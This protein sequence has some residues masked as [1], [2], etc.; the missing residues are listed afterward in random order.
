MTSTST[1]PLGASVGPLRGPARLALRRLAARVVDLFTVFF[2][3]FALAVTALFAVMPA[4]TD[5]LDIGPWGRTLAP[6]LLFVMIAVVYETV[7][8]SLRGQ[9][10]GKDLLCL[11]VTDGAGVPPAAGVSLGR[12]AL[13]AMPFL[14]PHPLLVA[15]TLV[16]LAAPM[17]VGRVSLHDLLTGT[18][19]DAYDA[20]AL[21]GPVPGSSSAEVEARYGPRSWWG[22]LTRDLRS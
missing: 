3:T 2:L 10:P 4:L 9:T 20:D 16:V 11:R 7:F 18:D 13:M 21:E 5:A 17:A 6:T 8:V 1:T 14:L 12:S 22:A 15:T 19:V